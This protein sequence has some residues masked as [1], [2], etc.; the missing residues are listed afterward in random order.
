MI[1]ERVGQGTGFHAR[2]DV[3]D[4]SRRL[5][6]HHQ[7]LVL[8]DDVERKGFGFGDELMPRRA[9]GHTHSC[10]HFRSRFVDCLAPHRDPPGANLALHL[11]A[12]P[13][14]QAPRQVN[15]EPQPSVLG[16]DLERMGFRHNGFSRP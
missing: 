10:G 14:G 16:P 2:A 6:D 1:E 12:A 8:I 9:N 5:V 15:V 7:V 3:H 4:H 11:A 13:I